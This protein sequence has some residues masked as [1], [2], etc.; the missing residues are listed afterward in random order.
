M[1][2][3]R[4]VT[5]QGLLAS[6]GQKALDEELKAAA[7]ISA[8]NWGKL[9]HAG[10]IW[11]NLAAR[12]TELSVPARKVIYFMDLAD[13]EIRPRAEREEL[14]ARLPAITRQCQT[15]LS[16]NLKEAW[17]MAEVFGGT[18]HGRK[19]AEPDHLQGEA[20]EPRQRV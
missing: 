16:F 19:D 14:L 3:C 9:P 12:L 17:Q 11:S 6:V 2:A 7:Y 5:W 8:V 18:F 15:L 10:E 20:H 1:A 4:D 13:F